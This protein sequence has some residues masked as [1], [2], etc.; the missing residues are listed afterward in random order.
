MR[1][2]DTK[3]MQA[4]SQGCSSISRR[5]ASARRRVT[6]STSATSSSGLPR[7]VV[8]EPPLIGHP[9][10]GPASGGWLKVAPC[11][12]TPP[13]MTTPWISGAG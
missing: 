12:I 13:A 2:G 11:G 10:S 3:T 6:S 9:R 7:K 8:Q 4:A 5:M 1:S